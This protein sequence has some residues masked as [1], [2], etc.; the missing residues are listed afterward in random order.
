M[1]FK[2]INDDSN[3]AEEKYRAGTMEPIEKLLKRARKERGLSIDDV[4]RETRVRKV[5][6][7]QFETKLPEKL[8]VYQLGYL[9]LYAR[10]LELDIQKYVDAYQCGVNAS[11]Q[12]VTNAA[13]GLLKMPFG[14]FWKNVLVAA[15]IGVGI[16]SVVIFGIKK[17]FHEKDFVQSP[18]QVE[19]PPQSVEY[20]KKI[21]SHTYVLTGTA[22]QLAKIKIVASE[23]TTFTVFDTEKNVIAKGSLKIGEL[24]SLPKDVTGAITIRTNLPDVLVIPQV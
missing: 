22:E 2:Q 18:P 7:K 14:S 11:R 16:T 24:L 3:M 21:D 15:L 12:T 20:I 17:P 4:A 19:T 8:D 6:L 13:T 10:Y 23:A 5:H 9:R 1:Q